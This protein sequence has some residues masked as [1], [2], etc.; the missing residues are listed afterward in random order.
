[1]DISLVDVLQTFISTATIFVAIY[2]GIMILS[3]S[4]EGMFKKE[5]AFNYIVIFSLICF[6][7][8]RGN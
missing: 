6:V 5:K 7:L 4:Q 3:G 1:M 2:L 8:F